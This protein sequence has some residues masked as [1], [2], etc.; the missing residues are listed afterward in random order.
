MNHLRIRLYLLTVV[1]IACAFPLGVFA[2]E[3]VGIFPM[4]EEFFIDD[5]SQNWWTVIDRQV[6][7]L[8]NGG[9]C[10]PWTR[11]IPPP[12]GQR[13]GHEDMLTRY[14]PDEAACNG[15]FETFF[16]P[17]G[18]NSLGEALYYMVEVSECS[19][20]SGANVCECDLRVKGA[21]SGILG[22][23]PAGTVCTYEPEP[24]EPCICQASRGVRTDLII[25]T[26]FPFLDEAG[27]T[28]INRTGGLL[29]RPGDGEEYI[30]QANTCTFG[31]I[32]LNEVPEAPEAPEPI[33]NLPFSVPGTDRLSSDGV[34]EVR[35]LIG[36]I[37]QTGLGVMGSIALVM[38]IAGGI[39]WM[40]AAG[41]SQRVVAGQKVIIWAAL[42][43]FAILGSYFLVDFVFEAFRP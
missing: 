35:A 27:C 20:S 42:G 36:R 31:G 28:Q 37:I 10:V 7:T 22:D 12:T 24:Q 21:N 4:E 1:G 16:L 17:K 8:E 18:S 11:E 38:I 5:T 9:V 2:E 32:D 13:I 25:N 41:N 26:R 23:V 30:V 34:G 19:F 39:M 15:A 14:F 6:R 29:T 43:M 33:Q 40:T 3:T